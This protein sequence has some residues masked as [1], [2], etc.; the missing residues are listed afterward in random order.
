M[1]VRTVH[2]QIDR[3]VVDGLPATAHQNFVKALEQ[4]LA[5]MARES[6]AAG[7]TLSEVRTGGID[8]G[9]LPHRATG[10]RAAEQVVGAIRQ[11]GQRKVTVSG[12]NA[13]G[14]AANHA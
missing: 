4:R 9:R 7:P 5:E 10:E 6:L 13:Q 8:A 11:A 2:L 1:S 14:G 12:V 3:I